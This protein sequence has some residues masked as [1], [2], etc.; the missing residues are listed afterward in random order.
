MSH[1]LN[2]SCG[3]PHV[4]PQPYDGICLICIYISF[5]STSPCGTGLQPHC[6]NSVQTSRIG[7]NTESF[8]FK[9]LLKGSGSHPR[10]G[11]HAFRRRDCGIQPYGRLVMCSTDVELQDIQCR[12]KT[13]GIFSLIV[14]K[15]PQLVNICYLDRWLI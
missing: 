6:N 12:R 13:V 15:Y 3:L 10:F 5:T 14:Q 4:D 9:W 1:L 8:G 2:Q 11:I 7:S